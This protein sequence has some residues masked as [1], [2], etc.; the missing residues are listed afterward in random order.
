VSV[1]NWE[2][3]VADL[4]PS[5]AVLVRSRPFAGWWRESDEGTT[6]AVHAAELYSPES[7]VGFAA[8]A[9]HSARAELGDPPARGSILGRMARRIEEQAETIAILQAMLASVPPPED[10]Q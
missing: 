9:K 10:E 6:Q 8:E 3:L 2:K 5:D 1:A 7:V 4:V